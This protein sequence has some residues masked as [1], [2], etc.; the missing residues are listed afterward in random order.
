[1]ATSYVTFPTALG[2]C[3][4]AWTA[5][6]IL[7]IQLP[8]ADPAATRRALLR[9]LPDAAEARP[10]PPVKKAI[11][12]LTAHLAGRPQ[13]LLAL[14]LDLEALPPFQARVYQALRAGVPPGRTVSY[15]TLAA[16]ADAPG[17]ARAVG[18]ALSKNELSLAVPCHRVIAADGT[19]GG[20]SASPAVDMKKKLLALEGVTLAPR[21]GRAPRLGYD[22]AEAVAH[23]RAA[24]PVMARL[25]AAAPP[26]GLE[27]EP[28]RSVFQHLAQTIVY[29]Q[30]TGKAAATIFKRV[31]ARFGHR[32]RLSAQA[33]VEAPDTALREVGLSGSKAAS[34]RDLARREVGGL[35]PPVRTLSRAS[36]DEVIE[37]LTAVRGIGPWSAQ[38]ILIFSMG[39]PDVMPATDYGVQKGFQL[40]Y[41]KREL[42][43]PKALLAYSERWRPFRS[44]AA[45]YLWR[46][47][48]LPG[49]P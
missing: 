39:R 12:A 21:T 35:L 5:R 16:M 4:L 45:W 1:M 41:R 42:P 10:P 38:M 28:F 25:I 11:A 33:V 15:S 46:A 7:R 37:T 22:P 27:P 19:A 6:G 40:A 43:K 20:F 17:A 8:E 3:G 49:P 9:G 32:G 48:E 34:L 13:D 30:L 47:T 2:E 14:P 36:D 26:F 24:D 31:Q 29:Q 44:A 23:L 18:T